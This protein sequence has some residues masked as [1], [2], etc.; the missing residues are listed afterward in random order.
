M[1]LFIPF[2]L[3]LAV[4]WLVIGVM[5]AKFFAQKFKGKPWGTRTVDSQFVYGSALQNDRMFLDL[6][7]STWRQELLVRFRN[8]LS[9]AVASKLIRPVKVG[10]SLYAAFAA[11]NTTPAYSPPLNIEFWTKA[12]DS[13]FVYIPLYYYQFSSQQLFSI[14]TLDQVTATMSANNNYYMAKASSS[15]YQVPSSSSSSLS[16][17]AKAVTSFIFGEAQ[18]PIYLSHLKTIFTGVMTGVMTGAIVAPALY[19]YFTRNQCDRAKVQPAVF[20]VVRL[21][22]QRPEYIGLLRNPQELLAMMEPE[23]MFMVD[24]HITKREAGEV[25]KE[26]K[27]GYD[28]MAAKEQAEKRL[29]DEEH[30]RKRSREAEPA[31]KQV[32][33]EA[34]RPTKPLPVPEV[35]LN[36]PSPATLAPDLAA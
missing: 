34:H 28:A 17:V 31:D 20:H 19:S 33:K 18:L 27:R 7:H 16:T 9:W 13:G 23:V 29:R 32:E 2:M 1:A 35:Q 5:L 26:L 24:K 8:R 11:T 6:A 10:L 12:S 30:Q 15:Y 36:K 22:E 21:F 4:F 3:G 14:N 25:M